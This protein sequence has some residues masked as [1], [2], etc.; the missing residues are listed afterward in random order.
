MQQNDET[1]RQD[2]GKNIIVEEN[3]LLYRVNDH[4]HEGAPTKQLIKLTALRNEVLEVEKIHS[5]NTF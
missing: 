5:I 3:L 2:K 4:N 1:L